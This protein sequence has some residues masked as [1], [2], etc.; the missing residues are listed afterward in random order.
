MIAILVHGYNVWDGGRATI[1]K[2]RP[3]L[4]QHGIPYI[5]V[6]YGH[7]GIG[8]TYTK[9][10]KIA[11]Q[12][13]KATL[14]AKIAE[15]EVI[16]FGHSNGCAILDLAAKKYGAIASKFVYVNPALDADKIRPRSV[17]KLD[18]WHSPSDKPVKW[19]RFLPHHP[20][21]DMGATGYDGIVD[22]HTTNF[23]KETDFAL[24]SKE[25]SDVFGVELLPYFAGKIISESL[26]G[27]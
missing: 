20:W 3:F 4:A 1:G 12:I 17:S 21:G 13:A 27:F 10:K 15:Q 19:A 7:F 25:H 23:N 5:M 18:V 8:E 11:K 16:C 26:R 24:S 22:K 2:L 9:N 6:N 14:S